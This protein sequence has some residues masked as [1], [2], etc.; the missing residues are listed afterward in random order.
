MDFIANV[1]NKIFL[2]PFI[3]R[4]RLSIYCYHFTYFLLF[5]TSVQLLWTLFSRAFNDWFEI[6]NI[7]PNLGVCLM[8]LIQYQ[9]LH[10]NKELYEKICQHFRHD[11]WTVVTDS[12]EHK[13]ILNCYSQTTR[14]IVRF[15]FYYTIFLALVVNLFPQLIMFYE[16][17][18]AGK[19]KQYLYPFDGWYPFDKRQWYYVVYTWESFMTTVV[20]FLYLFVNMLHITITRNICMELTFLGNIME[21]I[22]GKNEVIKIQQKVDIINIHHQISQKLKII[23]TKHQFIDQ[24]VIQTSNRWLNY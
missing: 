23:V 5:L 22:I 10:R 11:L 4:T 1:G 12:E 6:V 24:Y 13:S 14:M 15:E 19:E 17:N 18:V 9:K 16:S 2:C 21:G 20:I 8:I 3:G 7:A